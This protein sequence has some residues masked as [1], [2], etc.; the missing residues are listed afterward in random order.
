MLTLTDK[1]VEV[2]Q[3]LASQS[4]LPDGAGLRIVASNPED[5]SPERLAVILT[6]GPASGDN[7]I[8]A[9]P[10]RVYLEPDTAQVLANQQLDAKVTEQGDVKFLIGPKP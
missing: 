3:S 5:S 6:A 9:G 1:A 8:E 10:A 2:I 4:D 7:V